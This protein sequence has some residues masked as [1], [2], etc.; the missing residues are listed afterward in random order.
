MS[1]LQNPQPM[2]PPCRSRPTGEQVG[3]TGDPVG[4]SGVP[5]ASRLTTRWTAEHLTD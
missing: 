1:Y 5:G 2:S 4:G 3:A